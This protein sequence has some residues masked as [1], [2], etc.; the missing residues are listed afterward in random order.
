[1]AEDGPRAA[2]QHGRR[3]PLK[4]RDRRAPDGVDAAVDAVEAAGLDRVLDGAP[5]RAQPQQLLHRDVS[6]LAA[7]G[8]GDLHP[9]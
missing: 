7:S 5:S 8:L 4:R 9:Q 1:M 6:V 2:G 3:G